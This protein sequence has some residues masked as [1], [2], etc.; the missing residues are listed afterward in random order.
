MLLYIGLYITLLYII[1]NN[2]ITKG[3]PRTS[4]TSINYKNMK[5]LL[6]FGLAVPLLVLALSFGSHGEW[7]CTNST[8]IDI[9]RV[10]GSAVWMQ[11]TCQGKAQGIPFTVGPLKFNIIDIDLSSNDV[12]L[13]PLVATA[14][15]SYLQTLNDIARQNPHTIAGVN[16]GYFW[17][18]DSS[19]FKDMV[20]RGKTRADAG[21]S[22]SS[23]CTGSTTNFG[24]S[25]SLVKINGSISGCNCDLP[26][27]SVPAVYIINGTSSRIEK[28]V[29]GGRVGENVL[30]AIAAGPNLVTNGKIDI[31]P[32][33]DNINIEV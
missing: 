33:D 1:N 8:S 21:R 31:D 4:S 18:L 3:S 30:N 16:G 32:K 19:S 2:Y 15:S 11:T 9:G 5:P 14:N 7:Q 26:G 28:M 22:T 10:R 27:Y 23:D 17:R 24:V 12:R 20:C 29:R 13:A 25:D 6:H